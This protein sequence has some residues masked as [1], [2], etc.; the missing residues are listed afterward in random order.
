M[1]L[2]ERIQRLNHFGDCLNENADRL[3]LKLKQ[4]AGITVKDSKNR[5]LRLCVYLIR[6]MVPD[7]L[8][9][10]DPAFDLQNTT[11]F[12]RIAVLLP[13]NSV[14][15]T[16]AMSMASAYL[17]GNSV[18]VHL[19]SK[20]T[21]LTKLLH[22]IIY[23]TLPGVELS[24]I[25]RGRDFLNSCLEREDIRLINCFSND[26]WITHYYKKVKNSHKKFLF[27]GPGKDPF[28][29][30][31][32][33]NLEK[34]IIAAITAGFINSGQLC[35]SPERFYVHHEIYD[36][37]ISLLLTLVR[38]VKVGPQ[39]N[40][41]EQDIG[42]LGST[43]V[44]EN[45]KEQFVDAVE[46]GAQIL[47][48]GD[49]QHFEGDCLPTCMPTV[50]TNCNHQMNIMINETFGPVIPIKTFKDEQEVLNLANDS[51]YGLTATLFGGSQNFV[52]K[53]Q[54]SYGRIFHNS[55]FA[56]PENDDVFLYWG[57]F[58]NSAWVWEWKGRNFITRKGPRFF[59]K[60]FSRQS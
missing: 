60:E 22:E 14:F 23:D 55:C 7:K 33:A 18:F 20:F 42:P 24:D 11:P 46:K 2:E 16:M 48:G 52:K 32:D 9:K 35:C 43:R 36:S 47:H 13:Y 40:E 39:K 49:F 28:I 27:E 21:N 51:Q 56:D 44:V 29:V 58:G 3:C 4:A 31:P 5:D 10:F 57:G 41:E 37:F 54:D 45:I 53:L 38:N 6:Q 1:E 15:L 8:K 17:V 34:A 30:F 25:E 59:V 12:G 50:M 19:P 26:K